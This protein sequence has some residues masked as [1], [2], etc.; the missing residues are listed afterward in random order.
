MVAITE[1]KRVEQALE[2]ERALL[3]RRVEERT[4]DLSVA[5][6]ELARAA[7]L[8]DEF[9]ASMSHELRTPLNSILGRSQALQEQI[10]GPLTPK[11]VEVVRG[12]EESGRHLL[13]LINDILDVSKIEAGQLDLQEE[14]IDVDIL[15]RMCVRMVAQTALQKR[16]SVT[17]TLDSLVETIVADERRLKQSLS[18][19]SPTQLSSYQRVARL[20]WKCSVISSS[21]A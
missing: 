7:R 4:A 15:C 13:A 18:I 9:L 5:N 21:R 17:S 20:A 11:Q 19:C 14:P 6:A 10:Y 8:K 12:V 3:A 2:A 16:I 1:R